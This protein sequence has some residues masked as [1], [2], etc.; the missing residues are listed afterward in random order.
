MTEIA[1]QAI[2][3]QGV[4]YGDVFTYEAAVDLP[5]IQESEKSD[6][7][8]ELF[9]LNPDTGVAGFHICNYRITHTGNQLVMLANPVVQEIMTTPGLVIDN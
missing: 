6:I 3:N 7:I 4:T 8:V 1:V 2:S 5:A 9:V